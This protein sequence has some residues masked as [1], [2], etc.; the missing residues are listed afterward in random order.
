MVSSLERLSGRGENRED[1]PLAAGGTGGSRTCLR[2]G[3]L[4]TRPGSGDSGF[5]FVF[6]HSGVLALSSVFETGNSG[7]LWNSGFS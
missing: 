5:V 1:A 4:V 3:F 2:S 6:L 7:S